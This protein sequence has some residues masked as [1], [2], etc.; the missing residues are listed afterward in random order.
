MLH[1]FGFLILNSTLA[2]LNLL[3]LIAMLTS[4]LGHDV[5][6]PGKD[7]VYLEAEN[8]DL[9]IEYNDSYV[10][11]N[12]HCALIFSLIRSPE[13]NFLDDFSNSEAKQFRT[14]V[15]KLIL[16]TN[17][18]TYVETAGKLNCL[19]DQD[20]KM[21]YFNNDGK[22]FILSVA[23]KCADVGHYAK[24]QELYCQWND[25]LIKEYSNL[26][27]ISEFDYVF[28]DEEYYNNNICFIS[29][30]VLPLYESW[31]SFLSLCG[32]DAKKHL[33]NIQIN[34]SSGGEYI[35]KI[36]STAERI[37]SYHFMNGT[38]VDSK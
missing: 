30:T 21:D 20:K 35:E 22:Q 11:E 18:S 5:G 29:N 27:T 26:K 36:E 4:C 10:L 38:V 28:K 33:D 14:L 31:G 13:Y 37:A 25:L 34:K 32:K 12:M 15:I 7:N 6:H 9:C 1:S 3:E 8:N 19:L 24:N 23:L 2:K 16:G 17:F